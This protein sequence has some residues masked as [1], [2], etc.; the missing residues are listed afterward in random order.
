MDFSFSEEQIA[1]RDLARGILE[2]EVSAERLRQIQAD[3]DWFDRELWS[4]LAQAGLLGLMVPEELGGTGFG[5][6][7]VCVLLHEIGRA[8]APVPVFPT[9]ALA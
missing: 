4:T 8:V 3:P 9:L 2:Q 5:L 7:E 6:Q 1:L